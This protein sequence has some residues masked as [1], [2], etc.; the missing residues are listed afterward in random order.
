M[1]RVA[2][3]ILTA[4]VAGLLTAGP[5]AAGCCGW[6][7][8]WGSSM[9]YGGWGT[10]CCTSGYVYQQ[11]ATVYVQPAPQVIRVTPPPVIVKVAPQPVVLQYIQPVAYPSLWVN[12]GPV[13]SGPGPDF[14][15]TVYTAPS[16][17]RSYPYA[18]GYYRW[19][20]HYKR[21]S[22]GP[23]PLYR[24]WRYGM[25]PHAVYRPHRMHRITAYRPMHPMHH[26]VRVRH[27]H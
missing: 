12:Q 5:A 22:Y 3:G 23:R 10:G 17:V 24:S 19:K 18:P 9:S 27:R 25:R 8:G 26:A 14:S 13:Y 20:Q 15:P 2:L 4:S 1:Y 11:P 21:W 7:G 6:G 16:A